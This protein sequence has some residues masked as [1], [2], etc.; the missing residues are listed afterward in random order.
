MKK[1]IKH[2]VA[3]LCALGMASGDAV[4]GNLSLAPLTTPLM[5]A[6]LR[7][8]T[9]KTNPGNF[10]AD[11]LRQETDYVFE[12]ISS[13]IFT[14]HK[15]WRCLILDPGSEE[16]NF[17]IAVKPSQ[18][19]AFVLTDSVSA[20]NQVLLAEGIHLSDEIRA[21]TAA[22][23]ALLATRPYFKRFVIISS[24]KEFTRYGDASGLRVSPLSMSR[25]DGVFVGKAMILSG[26]DLIERT[27][28]LSQGS[29]NFVS[30]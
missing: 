12:P 22:H 27:I 30:G 16:H 23:E 13:A 9:I 1:C 11:F 7:N 19:R 21:K 5:Q 15:L 20:F 29:G 26:A 10:Y 2:A 25:K 4:A 18:D 8:V 24:N 14:K 17:L 28:T 3:M 6:D